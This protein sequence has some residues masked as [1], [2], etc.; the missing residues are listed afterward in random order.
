MY[1]RTIDHHCPRCKAEPGTPC[2]HVGRDYRYGRAMYGFHQERKDIA[3][4]ARKN[5]A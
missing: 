5:G 2:T 1:T 4:L 3:K